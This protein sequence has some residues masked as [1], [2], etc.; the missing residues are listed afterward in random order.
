ML[1]PLAA[2]IPKPT[3][4]FHVIIKAHVAW[5]VDSNAS[6]TVEEIHEQQTVLG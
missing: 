3:W 1:T 5:K 4:S 2:V 6:E